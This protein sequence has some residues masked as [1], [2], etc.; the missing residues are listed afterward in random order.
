MGGVTCLRLNCGDEKNLVGHGP[1]VAVIENVSLVE[2]EGGNLPVVARI[3]DG[4]LGHAASGD[5][6]FGPGL[7]VLAMSGLV[8]GDLERANEVGPFGI[9]VSMLFQVKPQAIAKGVFTE[10]IIQLFKDCGTFW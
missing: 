5:P 3:I 9:G 7:N 2:S 10:K 6:G 1:G 4:D 8:A